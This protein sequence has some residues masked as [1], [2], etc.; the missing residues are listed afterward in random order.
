MNLT[1]FNQR[2]YKIPVKTYDGKSFNIYTIRLENE[3][4]TPFILYPGFFQDA[5]FW[6]IMGGEGS[7]GGYM[8]NQGCDVW[9]IDSRGTGKSGGKKYHT[10]LDDFAASDLPA[11]IDFIANETGKKPVLVGHS[12]GGITS[13]MCLM[14]SVKDQKG[15]VSLSNDIA[16]ERQSKLKG[17]VTL[18]SYPNMT[19][20]KALEPAPMQVIANVGIQI[21]IFGKKITIMKTKTLLKFINLF[22]RLPVPPPIKLRRAMITY[23]ILQFLL[24][25]ITLFCNIVAY[26]KAWDILYNKKT[27]TRKERKYLFYNTIDASYSGIINQFYHAVKRGQMWSADNSV[28]YSASYDRIKLPCSIV[29]IEF[30]MI[31]NWEEMKKYMYEEIGSEHKCFTLWKDQGHENFVMN[32]I[33]FEETVNSIKK[34]LELAKEPA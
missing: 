3:G 18:G 19:Y 22:T 12:Q 8:R 31:E 20:P 10:D 32:P 15:N 26:S 14:G 2:D 23:P 11:I 1:E 16:Q 28:N 7:F 34:V 21:S 17:L 29:G 6:S 27:V 24:F 25:P 30:D 33:F 13:L 4:C 5:E 9:M